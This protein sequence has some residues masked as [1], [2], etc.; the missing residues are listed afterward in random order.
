M[1]QLTFCFVFTAIY[2]VHSYSHYCNN[3]TPCKDQVINCASD[4]ICEI[5]C[6]STDSCGGAIV[7]GNIATSVI[8]HCI[9][10]ISCQH[11]LLR[12]GHGSCTLDCQGDNPCENVQVD[13]P[14]FTTSFNCINV[15]SL[16]N[17]DTFAPTQRPSNYP[18]IQNIHTSSPTTTQQ[19]IQTSSPTTTA[20]QN[21]QTSSPTSP[22][23]FTNNTAKYPDLFTYISKY[24]DIITYI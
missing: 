13:V 19:N 5:F 7:N 14:G 20:Q 18:T 23:V 8:M 21:I 11:A 9:A 12:C 6:Q 16:V 3:N 15:C 24:P 22:T 4:D 10:P 2:T 17:V 1:Y